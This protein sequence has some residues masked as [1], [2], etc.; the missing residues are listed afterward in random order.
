MC[1]KLYN[2]VIRPII[3][4]FG[5]SDAIIVFGYKTKDYYSPSDSEPFVFVNIGMFAILTNIDLIRVGQI[6]N[7]M[8]T[9]EIL[10]YDIKLGCDIKSGFITNFVPIVFND[11]NILLNLPL[12]HITLF[13]LADNMEFVTPHAYDKDYILDLITFV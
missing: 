6:C 9:Y 4:K 1:K 13:G 3:Q 2:D 11:K 12:T 8:S 5:F 7:S 10:G